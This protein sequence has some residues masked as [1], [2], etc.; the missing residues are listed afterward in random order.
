MP[1]INLTW[2][3]KLFI[4]KKILLL[5][6]LMTAFYS[7]VEDA[8]KDQKS[9][10]PELV[11]S[12]EIIQ[13][14]GS[15]T[16]SLYISTQ[17]KSDCDYQIISKP[18]WVT[19]DNNYGNVNLT[20]GIG[21]VKITSN[22]I[23]LSPGVYEG[24]LEFIS[25]LGKKSVLLKAV[26]GEN[27]M[28]SIPKTLNFSAVNDVLNFS[29]KNEGNVSINY[30][31]TNANSNLILSTNVGNIGVGVTSSITAT[32]NRANLPGGLSYSKLYFT[33]NNKK[34]SI[35]VAIDNFKELK[36]SL[37]SDVIDAEYSRDK[38]QLVYVSAS[39]AR[40]NILKAGSETIESIPLVYIPT[41]VSLSLDGE[42]AV[43]GHDGHITYINLNTKS[44]IKTYSVSCEAVDIVLGNNKWAYVFPKE[45][46]WEY[47]RCVNMSL[48][49]DNEQL[50]TGG[51]MRA[52]TKARLHPSGKF[53]YGANNGLSPSDIEKYDIQNGVANLLYDSPYHG[54]YPMS[55]N[56]WFSEDGQRIFT[57]GKTVLKTSE[58]KS[59]DMLYNGKITADNNIEWLEHSNSKSNLYVILSDSNYWIPSRTP[60]INVYNATNLVFKSK[61]E[62][63]KFFIPGGVGGGAIYDALPYFV[64]TN[65]TGTGLIVI[66]KAK[67]S[68]LAN[69]W[70]IQKIAIE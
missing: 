22:L 43:V 66:T 20:R 45:N 11:F 13:F 48:P 69:E 63:E 64:F 53:I 12:D 68:G 17:P 29:F 41:C 28:Y 7:C 10:D 67:D 34:D 30:T 8:L 37:T 1:K 32:L 47:I 46:Q 14:N 23:N 31:I 24:K 39:P 70:A 38:D 18:S 56:L 3:F 35:S 40:L 51:Y 52:G 16:K 21:E 44:I 62:L 4:M 54:D 65:A 61:I 57:R 55:G 25:T 2:Y 26:V 36:K 33:I 42:T 60:F 58:S 9:T 15:E 19:V 27:A 6:L 5:L 50:S 59:L 49:T